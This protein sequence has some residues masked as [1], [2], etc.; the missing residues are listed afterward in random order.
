MKRWLAL[1]VILLMAGALWAEELGIFAGEATVS[2]ANLNLQAAKRKATNLALANAVEQALNQVATPEDLAKKKKEIKRRI[3]SDPQRFVVSFSVISDEERTAE[4]FVSV[5]ARIRLDALRAELQTINAPPPPV[6]DN[7]PRLAVVPYWRRPDGFALDA[8]LDRGLRERFG[9][10]A[11]SPADAET[12]EKLLGAPGFP[13]AAN[14]R[15]A[16]LIQ[17]AGEAG[18]RVLVLIEL[19]DDTPLENRSSTCAELAA[20]HV[21]DINSGAEVEQFP[22]SF[23]PDGAC[24][25]GIDQAARDLSGSISD[26]MQR[27]GLAGGP[28]AGAFYLEIGGV[29][30]YSRLQELQA[31]IRNRPNVQVAELESFRAG[32]WVVFRIGYAGPAIQFADELNKSTAGGFRLKYLGKQGNL[33]RFMLE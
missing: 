22:Y 28:G 9:S 3:L 5:E 8:E 31:F 7:K 23:P 11:Q 25:Q 19:R 24:A 27:H 1:I 33:L 12:V 17:T 2:M 18:L 26:V 6:V 16:E 20:V 4:Y 32:G 15:P 10:A 14:G 30:G 21:I 29:H 13:A